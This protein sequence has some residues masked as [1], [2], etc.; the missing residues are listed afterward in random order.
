MKPSYAFAGKALVCRHYR[1]V[2]RVKKIKYIARIRCPVEAW[3]VFY[4]HNTGKAPDLKLPSILPME[5]VAVRIGGPNVFVEKVR[6]YEWRL[7]LS[8]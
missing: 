2:R 7:Y 8:G 1:K 5:E 4:S 3:E 6:L